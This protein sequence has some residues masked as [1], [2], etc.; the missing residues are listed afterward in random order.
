M[1]MFDSLI[2]LL[3]LCSAI[4][5]ATYYGKLDVGE[6]SFTAQSTNHFLLHNDCYNQSTQ[7]L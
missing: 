6:V 1:L 5:S 4:Y 3:F 7:T 2:I